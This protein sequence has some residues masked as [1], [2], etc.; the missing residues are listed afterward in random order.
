MTLD[1]YNYTLQAPRPTTMQNLILIRRRGWSGRIASLPLFLVS[2]FLHFFFCLLRLAYKL[3]RRMNRHHFTLS[4]RV[5]R[6]GCA[7]KIVFW[8]YIG[9][10]LAD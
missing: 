8:L 9:A 7:V 6:Q 2:F 3:H 10:I 5:L 4:R 1:M